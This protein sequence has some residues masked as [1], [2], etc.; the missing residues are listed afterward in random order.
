MD[1][2]PASPHTRRFLLWIHDARTSPPHASGI[3]CPSPP[4]LPTKATMQPENWLTSS[5]DLLPLAR[6]PIGTETRAFHIPFLSP[7][8]LATFLHRESDSLFLITHIEVLT[9]TKTTPNYDLPK[10]R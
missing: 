2:I 8:A 7:R 1:A 6:P 9:P 5:G 3:I 4:T 10:L